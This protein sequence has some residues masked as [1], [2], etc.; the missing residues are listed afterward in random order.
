MI[1]AWIVAELLVFAAVVHLVGLG[2]AI[3]LGLLTTV[4][5][6]VTLR[7][8]GLDAA[9]S[10]RV[11]MAGRQPSDG[12]L[13]DGMLTALGALLLIWPG[14]IANFVGCALAASSIRTWTA[15]RFG[16]SLPADARLRSRTRPDV[17]DLA[18]EDWRP[19]D[20]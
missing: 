2:G 14:F 15:R 18:P 9:R 3:L 7:R 4:L 17:I 13:L 19:V 1:L 12:A 20:R 10:L 11:A 16:G 6:V 5:G 8:V